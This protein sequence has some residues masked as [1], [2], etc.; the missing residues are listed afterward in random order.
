MKRKETKEERQKRGKLFFDQKYDKLK[1]IE[2]K[3]GEFQ[4]MMDVMLI[5]HGPVTLIVDF[6]L[7]LTRHS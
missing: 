7:P 4:A 3:T 5:N 2:F 1:N 6:S